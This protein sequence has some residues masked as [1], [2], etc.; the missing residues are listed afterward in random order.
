VRESPLWPLS[1]RETPPRIRDPLHLL[2][3]SCSLNALLSCY[4]GIEEDEKRREKES[5]RVR[6]RARHGEAEEEDDDP[7]PM[8]TQ[9]GPNTRV[10][11]NLRALSRARITSVY[12]NLR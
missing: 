11:E 12:R 5:E 7:L 6:E 9:N 4:A 3:L 1:A 10:R 2:A 8:T